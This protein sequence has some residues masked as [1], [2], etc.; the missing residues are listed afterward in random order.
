M[1]PPLRS[2]ACCAQLRTVLESCIPGLVAEFGVAQGVNAIYLAK[3]IRRFDSSRILHAFDS[4]E[5]L[6]TDGGPLDGD[7]KK[8][9]CLGT[10][11]DFKDLLERNKLSGFVRPIPGLVQ[12]T[13]PTFA[14]HEFSFA[15]LDMDLYEPTRFTFQFLNSRVSVGGIVGFHDYEFRRTP[16]IKKVVDGIVNRRQWSETARVG[17]CIFFRK[18]R[19]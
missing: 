4:F 15:F 10:L 19:K 18:L 6:P 14:N 17:T 12:D 9:E 3:T 5:G 8:G 7:L 13:L 16:G 11:P 2:Q 1:T